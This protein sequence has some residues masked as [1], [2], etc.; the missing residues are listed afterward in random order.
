MLN[1]IYKHAGAGAIR[2]VVKL[3]G[4]VLHLD[5]EDDGK[6]FDT[7]AVTHRNGLKNLYIRSA[8][9][10]GTVSIRSQQDKGTAIHISLPLSV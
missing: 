4:N 9:W 2:I 3:K 7:T 1:N 5:V 10:N 8:R 6:G